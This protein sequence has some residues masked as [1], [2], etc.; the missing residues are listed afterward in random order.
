MATTIQL[1][2]TGK[3]TGRN[4]RA[5]PGVTVKAFWNGTTSQAIGPLGVATADAWGRY[6][7]IY[8]Y[9]SEKK[10][11]T[12]SD[13][14]PIRLQIEAGDSQVKVGQVAFNQTTVEAKQDIVLNYAC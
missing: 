13:T 5:I 4:G 14:A 7:L 6:K 12:F 9:Q 3:V 10:M 1:I 11:R 8:R 2:V